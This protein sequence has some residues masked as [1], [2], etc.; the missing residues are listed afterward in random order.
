VLNE[1]L[2][3]LY[4]D[5][6]LKQIGLALAIDTSSTSLET[7]EH[8]HPHTGKHPLFIKSCG[9]LGLMVHFAVVIL[10]PLKSSSLIWIWIVT[11]THPAVK[12]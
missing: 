2:S 8:L 7:F 3:A 11:I 12:T 4:G 9:S 5:M 6:S 10:T 1:L